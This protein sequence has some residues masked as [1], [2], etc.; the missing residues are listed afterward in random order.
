MLRVLGHGLR[1]P[2]GLGA[3]GG[4]GGV[5]GPAAGFTLLGGFSGLGAGG[6]TTSDPGSASVGSVTRMGAVG[7]GLGFGAVAVESPGGPS[8]APPLAP[9]LEMA[10]GEP[11]GF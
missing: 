2:G 6:G 4:G 10:A 3:A 5:V 9:L 1:V 7:R 8:L 11:F